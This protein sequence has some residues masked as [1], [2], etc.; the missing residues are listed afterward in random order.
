[1]YREQGS[2]EN[3]PPIESG[4]HW[5]EDQLILVIE[6]ARKGS[7]RH[8]LTHEEPFGIDIWYRYPEKFGDREIPIDVATTT[9]PRKLAEKRRK[10]LEERHVLVE[11]SPDKLREARDQDAILLREE[12]IERLHQEIEDWEKRLHQRNVEFTTPQEIK[13]ADEEL[14]RKVQQQLHRTAPRVI[15]RT[16][17]NRGKRARRAARNTAG[18][19]A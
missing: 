3:I 17:Y 19:S 7:A 5:A 11:Y 6:R 18:A 13:E 12:I 14:T 1:M 4:G 2:R 10:A 16:S 9:D 8:S 15:S